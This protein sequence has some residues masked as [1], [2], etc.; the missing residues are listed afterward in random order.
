MPGFLFVRIWLKIGLFLSVGDGLQEPGVCTLTFA[1]GMGRNRDCR[2]RSRESRT[3]RTRTHEDALKRPTC[4]KIDLNAQIARQ[5]GW[6]DS[7]AGGIVA[8]VNVTRRYP[9]QLF[10]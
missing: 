6:D 5:T 3:R 9:L 10:A 7:P 8:G 2:L 4:K 1:N